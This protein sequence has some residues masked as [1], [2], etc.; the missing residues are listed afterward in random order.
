MS[1]ISRYRDSIDKFFK[2]KSFINDIDNKY[3]NYIQEMLSKTDYFVSIVLLTTMNN[4]SKKNNMSLHGY[5]IAS[6]IE[7]LYLMNLINENINHYQNKFGN[8][9]T[10]NNM[11]LLINNNIYRSLAQNIDTISLHITKEKIIKV[12]SFVSKYITQ[13]M[14]RLYDFDKEP[15]NIW[16][17]NDFNKYKLYNK[18]CAEKLKNIKAFNK[19]DFMKYIDNV[20]V[21]ICKIA[22]IGG[23][24]LGGGDEKNISNLEKLAVHMGQLIKVATDFNNVNFDIENSTNCIYNSVV[25]LGFQDAFELFQTSKEKF[26]EGCMQ[27]DMHTNTIKEI[28]DLLETRVDT[29]IDNTN[30][31]SDKE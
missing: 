11:R 24:L 15:H 5:F 1:R 8:M 14:E 2:N 29:F 26:V 6:G 17:P 16:I 21:N 20:Y 4:V 22:L 31:Q 19:E 18:N 9:T 13:R 10:I 7:S 3:K 25:S 28:I 30:T 27:L 23:F 12:N